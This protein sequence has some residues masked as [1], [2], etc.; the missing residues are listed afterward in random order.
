MDDPRPDEPTVEVLTRLIVFLASN[1]IETKAH[2]M[3]TEAML[4][5]C[6]HFCGAE[7]TDFDRQMS[8]AVA[9]QKRIAQLYLL[10]KLKEDQE[11]AWLAAQVQSGTIH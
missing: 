4:K 3:A 5:A 9:L 7:P 8:E 6:L 2:G 1:I 11:L 10:G